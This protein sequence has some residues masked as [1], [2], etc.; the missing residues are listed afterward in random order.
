MSILGLKSLIR[1]KKHRSYRGQVSR[2]ASNLLKRNFQAS[3]PN[4]K[5]VTD[6]TEFHLQG[7]KLYLSPV[8]DLYNSAFKRLNDGK[9][10]ILHSDQGWQYQIKKVSKSFKRT[11]NYPKY[12]P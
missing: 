2:F 4:Q 11:R 8:L 12:V 9:T 1:I 10:P 6:V 7:Q 3:K 5:W